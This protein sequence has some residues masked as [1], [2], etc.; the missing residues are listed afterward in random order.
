MKNIANTVS[1]FYKY[2]SILHK[3]GACYVIFWDRI[4]FLYTEFA[5]LLL[6]FDKIAL[7]ANLN[8]IFFMYIL[9]KME[10]V[11]RKVDSAIRRIAIFLN[12][13]KLFIYWYKP[14]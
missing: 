7:L 14:D 1:Y 9:F 10:P 2:E 11:V 5:F 4:Y 13:L 12:F 6:S 3:K 8:R